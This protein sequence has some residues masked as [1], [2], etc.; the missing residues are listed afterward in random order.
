MPTRR[1][2]ICKNPFIPKQK[3][4]RYCS[5]FCSKKA[6]MT[7]WDK[8]NLEHR[9][10]Y[11]RK[12]MKKMYADPEWVKNMKQRRILVRVAAIEAYGGPIC[13]CDHHG[14][15]CGPHPI[16]FL[17]IDHIGGLNKT[18]DEAGYYLCNKLKRLG[19]PVG[20]RVL[21]HNCNSSLGS[22]G[23]CPM[24]KTEKQVRKPYSE[25]IS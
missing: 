24:S 2:L 7:R 5:R 15:P 19:Y 13:S 6:A 3:R 9:R 18:R 20:Y 17:A 22:Y 23:Y 16:E 4:S 12:Y 21:C 10:S 1:C 11:R 25:R 14:K 8:K